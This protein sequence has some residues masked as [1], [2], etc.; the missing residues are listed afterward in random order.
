MT[1]FG[2]VHLDEHGHA[3]HLEIR[4]VNNRFLKT[5]IHLP[6]ELA[7]LEAE[8]E[9]LIRRR[10]TRGTITLRLHVRDLSAAA[11]Q[12]LNAAA[13]QNYVRQLRAAAPADAAVTIDLATLAA[14]PGV[15]QPRELTEDERTRT[16][17]SLRKLLD[18]ALDRLVAMRERE[19]RML[20]ADIE[21]HAERIRRNL[22]AVRVRAPLVIEEYRQR[23]TAR[24]QELLA[25]SG[26]SLAPDDLLREVAIFAE[27]SD[28]AEEIARLGSHLEQIAEC[29]AWAEPAGRKLDFIVQEMLRE[30][31]TIGSKAGD[32]E[33]A[34]HVIEIK[35][36][37]D[38]LK[39]QV[40]NVE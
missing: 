20:A 3:F 24:V 2:D 14:L 10:L 15:C 1:G 5:S 7:Y 25:R 36:A 11:A 12:E 6:D 34:R 37:I 21:A 28:V 23:L 39:E 35:S 19:G 8:I 18:A 4:S 40:Q 16:W 22:D 26:A 27:R 33:I 30:A 38:R 29:D 9:P 31:N 32:G 13:I 17:D